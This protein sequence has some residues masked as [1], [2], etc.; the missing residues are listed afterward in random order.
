MPLSALSSIY[1]HLTELG[2]AR[3]TLYLSGASVTTQESFQMLNIRE[4]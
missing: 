1:K 3:F 4:C 2:M